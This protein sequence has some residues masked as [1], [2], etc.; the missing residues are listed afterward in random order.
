MKAVINTK[1]GSPENLTVIN[2]AIPEPGADEILIK[3]KASV[4]TKADT[5]MRKGIPKFSRLFMG[6]TK[7]KTKGMGTGYAGIVEKVGKNVS[8]FKVGD[9]VFGETGMT[10]GANAEYLTTKVSNVILPKPEFLDFS[11]AATLTDGFLTSFNFL[12]QLS[13]ISKGDHVLIIGA[14]GSLGTAAIQIAKHYGAVV[15]GVS[16]SR[17]EKLVFQL[18]ADE[19]IDYKIRN[20]HKEQERY[21]IIFDAIGVSSFR[22]SKRILKKKGTYLSP[23]LNMGLLFSMML[24]S[25]SKGKKA[26]FSATGLLPADKLKQM[27]GTLSD[28]ISNSKMKI[29]IDKK[30]HLDEIKE[31]HKYVDSNR[32]IG[33]IVLVG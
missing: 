2:T 18:G 14:S 15:T 10:F 28:H 17:N 29:V 33:N 25:F 20:Y 8:T 26:I 21:D 11:E 7:P 12:T 24:T 32:K 5:M 3:V 4:V 1:Y 9:E 22:K 23:V 19:H 16:S 30:Y 31:A 13:K 6:L 27:L